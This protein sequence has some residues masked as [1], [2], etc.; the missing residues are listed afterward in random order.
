M[1]LCSAAIASADPLKC[2]L[3]RYSPSQGLTAA[4]DRDTL[5]VQWNG[6][7]GVELRAR[8]AIEQA[9]PVVR[10]LAI[11]TPGREWTV[12]ATNFAPD[13]HVTAGRRRVSNQQLDRARSNG[14]EITKEFMDRN[15]W[16][17][18]W[19]APFNV[20]GVEQG[21]NPI[22]PDLPRQPA[23]IRRAAATFHTD[24]C[25]VRS[26]GGRLEVEFPGLS[27]GI[28]AGSLRVTAY[29][30][31]NLMRM[32][33]IAKTDE[34]FVAYK[35]DGGV[36]NL[37]TAAM[38][39]VMWVDTGGNVQ[40][41]LFGGPANVDPAAVRAKNR[42]LLAEG[43]VGSLAVFPPPHRFFFNREIEINNGYVYY[44]KDGDGTYGIGVR[45][46]DHEDSTYLGNYALYNAPPGTMQRMAMYVYPSAERAQ[47]ARDK[48][49]AFTHGDAFAEI[50]GYKTL[51]QDFHLSAVDRLRSMGSLDI[52][53]PDFAAMKAIGINIVGISEFHADQL[54]DDFGPG[55]FE[56]E[57]VVYEMSR[58]QSDTDF[59]VFPWELSVDSLGSDWDVVFPK[60]VY[61]TKRRKPGQPFTEDLPGFGK[62][63]HLDGPA[64]VL[65]FVTDE[66]GLWI[67]GHPR[68]KTSIGYPDEFIT[69][70][71]NDL[72]AVAASDQYLGLTFQMGMG[73]DQSAQ[74]LCEYRCFDA[75]D[76]LNNHF[77]DSGLQP[78]YLIVG[79]DTYMKHP[80]DDLYGMFYVN[81]V[82]LDRLP[83]TGE[84]WSSILNALRRGDHF[85]STGEIHITNYALTETGSRQTLNADL[86]WTFPLEFV[87]VVWGDGVKVDRQ[88]IRATDLPPFGSKHFS[89]P[90]DGAGKKWVRFAAWDSA[91]NGAFV[92][93]MW[94]N[95]GTK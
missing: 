18:F 14:V 82:K 23:E 81:Y 65:K 34:N 64:D 95:K 75:I 74:R 43:P 20:P 54:R 68:T 37:R 9:A 7:A 42:V 57:K 12:L 78:K 62:V 63:Y 72:R 17:A 71:N 36:K 10:E 44:R 13:F 77:A 89:I 1:V 56:D 60:P 40:H 50:P 55:R 24:A 33:A 88:V 45:Q 35:Y 93:P 27:M 91:G 8:Y 70:K 87:E 29:R 3:T 46:A 51:V 76:M 59:L 53:L 58:R 32:E 26:D 21:R 92:Q 41:Y 47:T 73:M 52:Q 90:F 2:D 15:A 28:F 11:R 25:A 5:V 38:P 30:G 6:D 69:T 16:Y 19:D 80:H 79:E 83:G 67:T 61:W 4:I 85:V 66:H 48:V 39:R 22:N 31:T 49:L 84:D 86:S 94:V